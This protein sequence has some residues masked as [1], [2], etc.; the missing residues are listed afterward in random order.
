MAT[1][2]QEKR[3]IAITL[4][5]IGRIMSYTQSTKS[6]WRAS[7]FMSYLGKLLITDFFLHKKRKFL[8]PLLHEEMWTLQD[9][10]GRFPDQ[11]I[12]EAET[13]DYDI[14]L[15]KRENVLES[16]SLKIASALTSYSK[17]KAV[18][19]NVYTYLKDTLKIYM[20]EYIDLPIK[21][22][23]NESQEDVQ[24]DL[25]SRDAR[26]VETCQKALNVMEYRDI[27]PLR[28]ERN[29]LAEYFALDMFADDFLLIDAFSKGDI[30]ASITTSELVKYRL[31]DSIIEIT[32]HKAMEE[33]WF[34]KKD[35]FKDEKVAELA[36]KY[37]YI[38][39][40]SADGDHV[41]K[42]IGKLGIGM[43]NVLWEYSKGLTGLVET[44]GGK[45][46]YSGGDDLVL[47][48]PA[49]DIFQLVSKI[50][51][52][53]HS[54][55]K[56]NKIGEKLNHESPLPTLSFGISISYY[57]FPMSESL[58]KAE[59]LLEKAKDTG[60]NRIVW[61]IRKHSGQSID[62]VFDKNHADLFKKALDII[63]DYESGEIF[64][65]S[66]G[67]YLLQHQEMLSYLLAQEQA[68]Q[69]LPN[70]IKATFDDE[71]HDYAKTLKN[72]IDYLLALSTKES[73]QSET[74]RK[75]HALL[76]YIELF[77]IN[78]E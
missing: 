70:Y 18:K 31:F 72:L 23:E 16:I 44:Y 63:K 3:Y 11:Y 50:D 74:V 21:T 10:V 43:S 26:I 4:G 78:E 71:V 14:L 7:Y 69:L 61:S 49:S 27:Y 65:H 59:S 1:D 20:L 29:Y 22:A 24:K 68:S 66:F 52:K 42:A 6:L 34:P 5:P 67:H 51:D 35:L 13:D 64:L 38:A 57:K 75:L 55:L 2:Y 41:G 62:S 77:T 60:R 17:N 33:N 53:F 54:L 15:T 37:K 30:T 56:D 8:K 25:R 32:A 9:G 73:D 39:Y 12:F 48:A 28:C 47:F 58:Y 46:I 76:R 40:V 19:E 45:V 36:A